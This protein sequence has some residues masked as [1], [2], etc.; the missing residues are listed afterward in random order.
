MGSSDQMG[1]RVNPMSLKSDNISQLLSTKGEDWKTGKA[2]FFRYNMALDL[3]KPFDLSR[4]A[5]LVSFV[6][7]G[8]A[9]LGSFEETSE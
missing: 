1:L 3:E 2:F 5:Q 6:F 7:S 4:V 8:N 9:K